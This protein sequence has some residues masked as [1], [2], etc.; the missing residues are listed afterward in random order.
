MELAITPEVEALLERQMQSGR[1][2]DPNE[3]IATALHVLS[4]STPDDLLDL[5]AKIDEGIASADRGEL[6]TEEE[7][8]AFLR[9]MRAKL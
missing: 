4:E 7:A 8:R 2:R 1:F 3:L 5:E 6:Y 9:A